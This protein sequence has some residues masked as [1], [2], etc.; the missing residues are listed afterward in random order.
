[1][2]TNETI[3]KGIDE[4]DTLR[5][6]L[7]PKEF[8]K[9]FLTSEKFSEETKK[10]AFYAFQQTTFLVNAW[11]SKTIFLKG[12]KKRNF[13]MASNLGK[14]YKQCFG[15]SKSSYEGT[16]EE[17]GEKI[18]KILASDIF[19]QKQMEIIC[20]RYGLNG[21]ECFSIPETAKKLKLTRT[22]VSELEKEALKILSSKYE[23][24]YSKEMYIKKRKLAEEE[25]KIL[26]KA[27]TGYIESIKDISI[28]VLG[29]STQT[30][31]FLLG[32]RITTVP[33]FLK[34]NIERFPYDL[35]EEVEIRKA[36]FF[37]EFLCEK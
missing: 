14:L 30:E 6:S 2:T 25:R 8:Q 11:N 7:L 33:Q 12:F 26:E 37:E 29:L 31:E 20:L 15:I 9:V 5:I 22:K 23:L 1:M 13:E 32:A 17:F 24:K 19:S 34:T 18:K 4:I 3:V 27:T 28:Y 16:A 36:T 21:T 35:R 10:R